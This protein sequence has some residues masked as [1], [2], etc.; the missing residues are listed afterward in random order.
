MILQSDALLESTINGNEA[1][2][3]D[4]IEKVHNS[5]VAP[6]FYNNEQA[7]R[8]VIRFAYISAIDNYLQ[9]QELP[10]G[11][12]YADL[13]FIPKKDSDKPCIIIELKWNKSPETA[14]EQIKQNDYIHT[15]ISMS[16]VTILVGIT[17][18][19]KTKKHNCKIERLEK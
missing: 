14:L 12:G 2:V 3:A 10:S 18:D 7:L 4:S 19:E 6:L 1:D 8:S 5:A 17:Y 15:V 16:K 11:K 13:V 9:I